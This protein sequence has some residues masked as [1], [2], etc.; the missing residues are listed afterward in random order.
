MWGKLE[1]F[2]LGMLLVAS[3]SSVKA[4]EDANMRRAMQIY[5]FVE[6][7][8]GDSVYVRMDE[9]VRTMVGSPAA[10]N[11]IFAT[12][13][14]QLGKRVSVSEW[15]YKMPVYFRDVQ[16]EKGELRFQL[17]FDEA[18]KATTILFTPAPPKSSSTL[19]D[20]AQVKEQ[21]IE[22][23]C[24]DFK[25]PGTLTCP[26]NADKFP[27]LILVHGSGPQ[28]RDETIG[29]NKPFRDIAWGLGGQGIA[30]I[31]YDKRTAVY[32][33]NS[34][35]S[36]K[37]ITLN[38]EVIDD[39]LAAVRLA[40]TIP[41][42][43]ADRVFVLGHSLGGMAAPLLAERA[44]KEVAGIIL[45]AAP[46]RKLEAVVKDQFDYIA[47]LPGNQGMNSELMTEELMKQFP[48]A[49]RRMLSE[50]NQV[51]TAKKLTLPM[52]LLQ[53]GRDYQVLEADYTLWRAA[54]SAHANV[55]FK[56]YPTLNHILQEGVGKATPD[57]YKKE[58]PVA[59]YVI[60]DIAAFIKGVK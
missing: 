35:P 23:R 28:D 1:Y 27:V 16:F 40:K 43:D 18:G 20:N 29:P 5:D 39:A 17:V 13:E 37:E 46:A 22:V 2:L 54:L 56:L 49:Y 3:C 58:A 25:L 38:E 42:A 44:G 59:A 33:Q 4:Q 41:G 32:G 15:Q 26:K 19:L 55:Q 9:K 14:N 57:E 31:R 21:A 53:G 11:G 50:Y 10:F 34:A 30:V 52:L 36:G 12:L 6:A 60:D 47:S 48:E 24:G 51:E 8:Q 45:V 7:G